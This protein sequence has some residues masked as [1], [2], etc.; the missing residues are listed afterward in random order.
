[1]ATQK[2]DEESKYEYDY[3]LVKK[4]GIGKGSI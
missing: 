2:E 1:M 3:Y 4:G